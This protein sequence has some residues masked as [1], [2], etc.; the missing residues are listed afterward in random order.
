MA[1]E[2][3][4]GDAS[5]A[6]ADRPAESLAPSPADARR[7]RRAR[8]VAHLLDDAIRLPVVRYR[9]GVDALAGVIPVVGDLLATLLALLVVWDAFRLGARKRLLVR[10]LLY[11]G[12]DLLVGSVPIVGDALD[13]VVKLNRRNV[14]LLERE[15]VRRD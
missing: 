3:A 9:V 11:V 12:I 4:G 13:A 10:M 15:L 5:A 1:P 2:A 7:L 14:R 6:L 8:R